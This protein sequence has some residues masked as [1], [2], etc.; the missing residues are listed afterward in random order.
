MRLWM[1]AL[2]LFLLACSGSGGPAQERAD[3]SPG[4]DAPSDGVTGPAV[5]HP[6]RILSLTLSPWEVTAV[7][8]IEARCAATDAD[9]DP[10]TTTWAWERDGT[11][12][13]GETAATL[14][15]ALHAK[16]ETIRV[17]CTVSDGEETASRS[18]AVT[19]RNSPPR[20]QPDA[21]EEV[22]YGATLAFDLHA[23]DADGDPLTFV[24]LAA[25]AG[26]TVGADGTVTWPVRLPMSG[27]RLDV[28]LALTVSDG[29]EVVA[30]ERALTVVDPGRQ[31]PLVRSGIQIP[32]QAGGL[33]LADLD[34][35]GV[36]E[37]LVLGRDRL[38]YTL[39]ADGGSFAQNW[40]YPFDLSPDGAHAV[41]SADLDGDGRREILVCAGGELVVL[42]GASRRP[43]SAG[44]RTSDYCDA[45]TVVDVDGDGALEAVML[46]GGDIWSSSGQVR[47]VDPTTAAVLW[48][49][50][51]GAYGRAL[52]VGD[53]DGD[54]ALEIVTSAGFVLDGERRT[55]EWQRPEGFGDALALADLGGGGPLRIVGVAEGIAVY[56]AVTRT[57]VLQQEGGALRAVVA[58]DVDDDGV[59]E[60]I[61]GAYG[62][63]EVFGYD[64]AG[65]A[66]T[67]LWTMPNPADGVSAVV[68]GDPDGDGRTDVVFAGGW[69]TT[70][71][72]VLVVAA[73]APGAGPPPHEMAVVWQN[74]DPRQLD[75]PF[76][77]G[78]PLA[79]N[80]GEQL[81]FGCT[82]TDS[83]FGG[84]RVIVLDPV[85]G[86]V[87]VGQELGDN[88]MESFSLCVAD[89]D[90]DRED[91]VYV[92]TSDHYDGY[93]AA[94]DPTTDT[95]DWTA[96]DS[97]RD[98]AA[99]AA[100]DVTGDGVRD[101]VA[102]TDLGE[103]YGFDVVH[104][105]Q[106]L[107][108]NLGSGGVAVHAI[109][110]ERDGPEELVAVL[111]GDIVMLA[112]QGRT[113]AERCRADLDWITDAVVGDFD[114]DGVAEIA[115]LNRRNYVPGE[116][117]VVS[118]DGELVSR[119]E[120]DDR[121]SAL[122]VYA[123]APGRSNLLVAL[124]SDEGDVVAGA[125]TITALDPYTGRTVWTAARTP[126]RLGPGG[127]AVWYPGGG[128]DPA[129][130]FGTTVL[131]GTTR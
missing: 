86:R 109:D 5:N 65:P 14:P 120:V 27:P 102:L 48:E 43:S 6:P 51:P 83:H 23:S 126:G 125:S 87:R 31:A 26:L 108:M 17:T 37:V 70:G 32:R 19:V 127:F 15:A 77:G 115:A 80:A 100:L 45:L 3:A 104:G 16:H 118:V 122:S 7:D 63:V 106:V 2:G 81:V 44:A 117:V 28:S 64:G 9:G 107:S 111:R 36:E 29:E 84:S 90:G 8:D 38:L 76:V 49:S 59:D 22:P 66:L 24:L 25:P 88:W 101:L 71:T 1:C 110:L 131:F 67:P 54:P 113:Y 11:P 55:V 68:V 69:D 34:G 79:T 85:T 21:P 119:V 58:H 114:G 39:R 30:D 130:V 12:I 40:M 42:D 112:R 50:D 56:D 33:R 78:R 10:L 91:E 4:H 95:V 96:P 62:G 116:I 121:A 46:V 98:G 57:V 105:A 89:Y 124:A 72:D 61:V 53:V 82:K 92:A 75:G 103:L 41:D 99:T 129:I 13:A 128:P 20:L 94:Y 73:L 18:V 35:D 47:I 97:Y 93:F 123:P 52:A 60:L 74:L